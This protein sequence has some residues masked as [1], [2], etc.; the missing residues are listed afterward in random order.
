MFGLPLTARP[1][2]PAL[3][4]PHHRPRLPQR[5]CPPRVMSLTAAPAWLTGAGLIGAAEATV[6]PANP[7]AAAATA[8]KK[9]L[10]I[11]CSCGSSLPL[12]L[13]NACERNTIQCRCT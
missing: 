13:G 9:V 2:T 5:Q 7:I 1:A 6:I 10:R 11:E 4:R 12:A 8:I 3:E